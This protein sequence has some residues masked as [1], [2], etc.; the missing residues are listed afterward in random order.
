MRGWGAIVCHE[1]PGCSK[2]TAHQ[3][4]SSS[5]QTVFI[6]TKMQILVA[7]GSR[8]LVVQ[9]S[10]TSTFTDLAKY[11]ALDG[12]DDCRHDTVYFHSL[13]KCSLFVAE[14]VQSF[15]NVFSVS[16]HSVTL[17]SAAFELSVL[18]SGSSIGAEG[19]RMVKHCKRLVSRMVASCTNTSGCVVEVVMVVAWG[20]SLGPAT[21]RCIWRRSRPR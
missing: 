15:Y 18:C 11:Q 5:I 16:C 14:F 19:A 4:S 12:L 3:T 6:G 17:Y 1:V 7:R 21:W 9:A 8:T 20:R 13:R 10:P 2:G